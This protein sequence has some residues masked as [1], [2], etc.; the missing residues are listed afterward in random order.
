MQKPKRTREIALTAALLSFCS[1]SQALFGAAPN[2]ADNNVD[3][4]AVRNVQ[5]S[6]G[7][8]N[9]PHEKLDTGVFV[10]GDVLYIRATEDDLNYLSFFRVATPTRFDQLLRSPRFLWNWGARVGIG[11]QFD[12][13]DSWDLFAQWTYVHGKGNSSASV[14]FGSGGSVGELLIPTWGGAAGIAAGGFFID[15][16]SGTGVQAASTN[17]NLV[18]NVVDLE[19]GRS[20][21][22][23][24]KVSV[25]PLIG[26]RGAII[27]Q[28]FVAR[29]LT[30]YNLSFP[31]FPFSGIEVT[32]PGSMKA[33]NNFWGI[34]LRGGFDFLWHFCKNFGVDGNMSGSLL[35]GSFDVDQDYNSFA[36]EGSG[37]LFL[38]PTHVQTKRNPHRA[39]SNL[40]GA[41]GLFWEMTYGNNN[42]FFMGVYYELATWFGQNELTRPFLDLSTDVTSPVVDDT[43]RD[44]GDLGL[45][46]VSLKLRFD[47]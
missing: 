30:Y 14:P 32:A 37:D 45:S 39:R 4:L 7:A 47:F 35:A 38:E 13:F 41:L 34:G 20:F 8:V 10:T 9:P 2:A 42:H 6:W 43:R 21:Y 17:W 27:N 44:F 19:L 24:R 16:S 18:M 3:M 11:Y 33:K 5:G 31:D 26:V 15:G 23:G 28:K 12:K 22:F 36:T 1:C 46:G 25:R 29:Y 40:E